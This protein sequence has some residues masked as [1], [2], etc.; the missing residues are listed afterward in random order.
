MAGRDITEGR[1]ERAIAMDVGIVS[2]GQYWQNTT[3]AYDVAIGGLPF[4]YAINDER[5]YVRQ[6]A[7]YRK[8]QFDNQAEPGEQSLTGWWI[9][10]QT[11]FH[12]GDG[13]NF[14][15]PEANDATGHYRFADSKGVNV[16]TK[17][18][19]TLLKNSTQTHNTTGAVESNGRAFQ[20]LRS[21]QWNSTSG[22]LLH[23]GYDL[24]KI[25]TDGTVTHFVD[26]NVS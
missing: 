3:E 18:Q 5:E 22:V 4:I 19:V 13:I 8:D 14:F 21:I 2:T 26:Y 15:D 20:Q 17:G 16:W 12:A 23:D 24:D 9:R 25:T 7:P 11:S 10:S 1:A 6:T